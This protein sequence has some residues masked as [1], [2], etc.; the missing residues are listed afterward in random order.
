MKTNPYSLMFGKEPSQMISRTVQLNEI[1]DAFLS[2]DANRQVF[3]ITGIRGS[4]KTVL[5]SEA[6]RKI[7]ENKDWITVELNPERDMLES[8]ASKLSSDISLAK[9][10]RSAKIN[11]SFWGFG[12]EVVGAAPVTDIETALSRM[13]SSLKTKGKKILITVDEAANTPYMK[14]FSAAFQILLRQDLPVFLLMTGLF[15]NIRALQ[16]EKTLTFL[17]RAP[18]VETSPLN[19][20]TMADNYEDVIGVDRQTALEMARMTKG[21][22]FAFQVLGYFA[23]QAK[24]YSVRVRKEFKQ[25]LEDYA[26]EK[27]WDELSETDKRVAYGIA[28][29]KTGKIQDVRQYLKMDTNSFNP[30]RARLVRKGIVDGS[31]H[32]KVSFTLP[33]FDEFILE[34]YQD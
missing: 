3:I 34:N 1:M 31:T 26:Y 30:Y 21:Y 8:L 13:L 29:S 15:E 7:S 9:I 22:S 4:G 25:Y 28:V 23:W 32:G 19:T 14:T 17:Y 18:K 12:L 2:E 33:L 20:G 6:A 5:M 27:I 11:L 10:F 24:G 16:N